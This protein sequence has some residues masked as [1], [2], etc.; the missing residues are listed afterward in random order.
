MRECQTEL[1]GVGH[2]SALAA[3]WVC[4]EFEAASECKPLT[5]KTAPRCRSPTKFEFASPGFSQTGL[6]ISD[7]SG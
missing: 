4:E 5:G 7:F 1:L 3:R 2:V 6:W